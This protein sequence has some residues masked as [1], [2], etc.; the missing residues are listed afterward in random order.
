[1]LRGKQ[2]IELSTVDL[3]GVYHIRTCIQYPIGKLHR[4][5]VR[6]YV[7]ACRDDSAMSYIRMHIRTHTANSNTLHM[8]IPRLGRLESFRP[9][10]GD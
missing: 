7:H 4:P 10:L 1:M 2:R 9:R 8:Y 6:T 5:L 3:T